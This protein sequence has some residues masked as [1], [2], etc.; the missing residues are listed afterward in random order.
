MVGSRSDASVAG[1]RFRVE[2]CGFRL[3]CKLGSAAGVVL[4]QQQV[5]VVEPGGVDVIPG[6]VFRA[7]RAYSQGTASSSQSL[8]CHWIGGNNG[9]SGPLR[10]PVASSAHG[11]EL[12]SCHACMHMPL[13]QEGACAHA[14]T[15]HHTPAIADPSAPLQCLKQSSNLAEGRQKWCKIAHDTVE[16]RQIV[17]TSVHTAAALET[18]GAAGACVESSRKVL[19]GREPPVARV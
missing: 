12:R 10:T 7:L 14:C 13:D 16:H 2:G 19:M 8:I 3:P 4:R 17:V 1:C 15:A 5:H 18:K 9:D 11:H 6:P